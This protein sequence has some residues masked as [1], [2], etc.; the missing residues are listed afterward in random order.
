MTTS[1][2]DH[3]LKTIKYSVNYA[4]RRFHPPLRVHTFVYFLSHPLPEHVDKLNGLVIINHAFS[5]AINR[6]SR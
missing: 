2:E 4:T 3:M 6:R 5:A 1:E